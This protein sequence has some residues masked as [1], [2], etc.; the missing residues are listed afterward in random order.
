MKV[1]AF[2]ALLAIFGSAQAG[3]TIRDRDAEKC[4]ACHGLANHVDRRLQ[5]TE[6]RAN[7]PVSIG[8]RLNANGEEVPS[9]VIPYGDSYGS[10][11]LLTFI[12]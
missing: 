5:D 7:E 2:S 4:V 10:A 1:E 9:R 3:S 8:K 11:F 6:A 12:A